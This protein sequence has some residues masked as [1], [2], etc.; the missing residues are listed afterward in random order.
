MLALR[1]LLDEAA[2][3]P[4]QATGRTDGGVE[5]IDLADAPEGDE[6]WG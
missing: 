6:T 5:H 4:G 2:R 3:A 1:Q